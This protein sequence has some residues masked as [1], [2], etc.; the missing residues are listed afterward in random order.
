MEGKAFRPHITL[1]RVKAPL[2]RDA[3]RALGAAARQVRYAGETEVRTVDLVR[4]TPGPGGSRYAVVEA[5][6]LGGG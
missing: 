4:S 1:A 2:G 5:A 3:A 6:P